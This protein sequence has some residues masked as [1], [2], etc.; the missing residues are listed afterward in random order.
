MET[1]RPSLGVL[2]TEP[3]IPKEIRHAKKIG[4]L[5]LSYYKIPPNTAL[6]ISGGR[7]GTR[8]VTG[9]STFVYPTEIGKE[10]SLEI[11]AVDV[12]EEHIRTA[13]SP[14]PLLCL[15]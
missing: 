5:F 11:M 12:F 7:R 9:S 15:M 13:D 4:L 14:P 1:Y 2:E 8:V 3:V 6:V 10:L